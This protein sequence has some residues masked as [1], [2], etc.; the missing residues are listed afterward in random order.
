MTLTLKIENYDV[1]EDGGPA[2][3][4]V[5]GRGFSAG[6]SSNMDWVLPDPARHI[7]SRHFEVTFQDGTYYLTDVSTNGIFLKGQPYRLDGAY[8]IRDQ[9]RFQVGHYILIASVAGSAATAASAPPLA[10]PAP[11]ATPAAD[12]DPWSLGPAHHEPVDPNPSS[13]ARAYEDF[14]DDFIINPAPVAPPPLPPRAPAPPV[15]PMPS[16][17]ASASPFGASA[18]PPAAG[19]APT[20]APAPAAAPPAA[21][22][23]AHPTPAG[24]AGDSS[25]ILRAFCEG[26]GLPPDMAQSADAEALARELGRAMRIA[27][28]ELMALL[29]D[30][31]NAKKFTKSGDRTMMGAGANNPLKFLP[32]PEQALEAMFIT[33]K[34]GFMPGADGLGEAFADVRRHQGAVFAAMQPALAH[35]LAD[36]APEA[37]EETAGSGL[38][39]A[40][41]KGKAWDTF[42]ERWDAKVEPHDNG[43]L[44][45]FFIHFAQAYAAAIAAAKG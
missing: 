1:L 7:S 12:A 36:L 43:M 37:V 16:Q 3:I 28:Q 15:P 32:T 11:A 14:A 23:P 35:L 27:A 31:A 41:R 18:A 10:A 26:A 2:H 30:R 39:G 34:A 38:L 6:R 42:V 29:Q 45:V 22:V 5:Q 19:F 33:P 20:P 17:S 40:G 25:A 24:A 44:D 9:D 21:A 8:A 13:G 4:T